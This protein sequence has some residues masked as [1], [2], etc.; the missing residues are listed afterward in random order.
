MKKIDPISSKKRENEN[1]DIIELPI[2]PIFMK[3]EGGGSTYEEK[4]KK[5]KENLGLF[6]KKI[7]DGLFDMYKS[8]W[9]AFWKDENGEHITICVNAHHAVLSTPDVAVKTKIG[10]R[11]GKRY[12]NVNHLLLHMIEMKKCTC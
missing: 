11:Q 10:E 1:F 9:I 8:N 7:D 5:Y 4:R 2:L 12:F 6:N 3:I